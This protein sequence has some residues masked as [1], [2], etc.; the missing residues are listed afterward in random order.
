MGGFKKICLG[1]AKNLNTAL[2]P[3]IAYFILLNKV[4]HFLKKVVFSEKGPVFFQKNV[5]KNYN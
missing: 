3:I 2:F 5:K 1:V 4:Q